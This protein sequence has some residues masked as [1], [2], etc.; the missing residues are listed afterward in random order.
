M[1]CFVKYHNEPAPAVLVQYDETYGHFN[2][3]DQ[4]GATVSDTWSTNEMTSNSEVCFLCRCLNV[5]VECDLTAIEFI[6]CNSRY[7]SLVSSIMATLKVMLVN[8][9]CGSVGVW[10][11]LCCV[12]AV[13]CTI[14]IKLHRPYRR[15]SHYIGTCLQVHQ[16]KELVLLH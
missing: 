4:N 16:K 10:I 2:N 11:V 12:R 9:C 1:S 15:M 14:G 13:L 7:V 3:Y 8:V 6:Q 5:P